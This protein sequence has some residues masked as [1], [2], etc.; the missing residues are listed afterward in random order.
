MQTTQ[1]RMYGIREGVGRRE[2]QTKIGSYEDKKSSVFKLIRSLMFAKLR[3]IRRKLE[4]LISL[5][6]RLRDRTQK[7][8]LEIY[9]V[10]RIDTKIMD[11]ANL[12]KNAL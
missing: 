9:N 10:S 7:D 4:K 5:L 1:F 8:N 3:D 2:R 12:I 6:Q 11:G